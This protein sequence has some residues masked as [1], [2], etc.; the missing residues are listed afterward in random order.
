MDY[1]E[2]TQAHRV[3]EK[4]FYYVSKRYFIQ[5]TL[6]RW[7]PKNQKILDIGCGTGRESKILA[8]FG[9]V[10]GIDGSKEVIKF[11]R[12][13]NFHRLVLYEIKQQLPFASNTFDMVCAFDVLEHLKDDNLIIKEIYRILKRGG[14]LF[15]IVPAYQWLFSSHDRA[16]G[17]QRRYNRKQILTLLK[18]AN[19]KIIKI[20]YTN[21]LLLLIAAPLRLI[22]KNK[23]NQIKTDV[24]IRV[25]N[26]INKILI[27][28]LRK[29]IDF[30]IK[31]SLCFGLSI[32][33]VAKKP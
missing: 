11:C 1:P 2:L 21:M 9:Q 14:H 5:K 26:F 32:T 33:G 22:N 24:S 28:L 23:K 7:S 8:H 18:S 29:E 17:H 3:E 12:D 10:T 30:M 6:E 15:L 25:P 4:H 27:A 20:S 13:K 16:L 19:F 31:Y